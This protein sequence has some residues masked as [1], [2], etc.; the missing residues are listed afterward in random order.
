MRYEAPDSRDTMARSRNFDSLSSRLT[1]RSNTG[2]GGPSIDSNATVAPPPADANAPAAA[3]PLAQPP[4]AHSPASSIAAPM[5][6]N[7]AEP[8]VRRIIGI[9]STS[10]LGSSVSVKRR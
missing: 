5:A 1:M 7:A 9:A 10:L 6:H 3:P 4:S 8:A 2:G